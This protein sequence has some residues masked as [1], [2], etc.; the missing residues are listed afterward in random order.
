MARAVNQTIAWIAAFFL[1]LIV[2]GIGLAI[3]FSMKSRHKDGL[4]SHDDEHDKPHKESSQDQESKHEAESHSPEKPADE[5]HAKPKIE[6]EEPH[7]KEDH[8]DEE[9]EIT[10]ASIKAKA[11]EHSP[12]AKPHH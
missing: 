12:E 7:A 5:G 1:S 8:G 6:H 4:G 10:P 2:F 3:V 11:E 9:K